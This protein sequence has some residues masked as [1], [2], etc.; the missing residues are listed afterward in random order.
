MEKLIITTPDPRLRQKSEPVLQID[1]EIKKIIKKMEQAALD[2]EKNRPNELSTAL[3]AVQIGEMKRIIVI[4]EDMED[5]DS[6]FTALI[7]PEVIKATGRKE[8]DFEGCLSV[9]DFYAKVPRFPKIKVKAK[10]I[11]G[12]TI[13]V[14]AEGFIARTLQHEIDHTNGILFVDRVEGQTDAFYK[15]AANGDLK[16]VKYDK[17][18]AAGIFRN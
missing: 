10:S 15:L 9:P 14:K 6:K 16:K 11:D 12:Q 7:N 1:A 5:K 18:I 8:S 2:W 17:V 3:A 13:F 4:R